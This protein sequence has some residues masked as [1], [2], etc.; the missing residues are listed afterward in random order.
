MAVLEVFSQPEL[1][2][3]N[4]SILTGATFIRLL[5]ILLIFV[6]PILITYAC[7]GFWLKVT[8]YNEQPQVY[9]TYD[10]L[11]IMSTRDSTGAHSHITWSTFHNYNQLKMQHLR[12]PTLLTR[13]NDINGDGLYDQLDFE[14]SM[15]L[16]SNEQV[17][18]VQIL[19]VFNYILQT[20]SYFEMQSLVHLS[21]D[22]SLPGAKL[23]VTGDLALRQKWPLGNQGSDTRY[24]IP[25]ISSTSIYAQSFELARILRSYNAR[26][27]T[28]VLSNADTVWVTGRG[29]NEPFVVHAVI[30]YPTQFGIL[31]YT[32]FWEMIKWGWIQYVSVLLLFWY[33]IDRIQRFIFQNQLVSTIIYRPYHA[34]KL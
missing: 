15:P 9:F 2:R 30:N 31:Y 18:G 20:Y 28:T 33:S 5:C 21:H 24:N 3:Y 13:E 29:A 26:N 8:S 23:E 14:L 17:T 19:L 34:K 22:S 25:V 27:V 1:K 6:P 10:T 7:G 16:N 12:I 11:V 32:G 4:A